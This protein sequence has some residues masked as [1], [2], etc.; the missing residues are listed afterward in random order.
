[1]PYFETSDGTWLFYT[2]VGTGPPV[3]LVH[4]WSLSS[5]MW[6]YQVRALVAA[7]YRCIAMDRHGRSDVPGSGYDLDT[8][9]ADLSR[10]F[11]GLDLRDAAVL[12]HSMGTCEATW[13]LA[14]TGSSRVVRACSSGP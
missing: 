2:D 3:L 11:E 9:A 10:L 5:A 6:E 4:A 1:M 8:L 13:Y 7:G 14:R 12:A